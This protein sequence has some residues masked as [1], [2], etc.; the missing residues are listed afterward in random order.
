MDSESQAPLTLTGAHTAMPYMR[1]PTL[2][3]AA[4]AGHIFSMGRE[5]SATVHG[6]LS[7][8]VQTPP[9]LPEPPSS[10]AMAMACLV[11]KAVADSVA[12]AEAE[13]V[14]EAAVAAV[15]AI[16]DCRGGSG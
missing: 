1:P 10:L 13:A 5:P 15:E 3:H 4:P 2:P 14:A 12:E 6:G 9:A 16:N 11:A 7:Q 8:T